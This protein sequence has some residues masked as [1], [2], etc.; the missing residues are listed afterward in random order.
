MNTVLLDM[1]CDE[2]VALITINRPQALNALSSEVLEDLNNALAQ[3]CANKDIYAL[4]ITGAGEKSFVAGADIAEMKDKNIDEAAAYGR[5]GNQIFTRVENFRCPVIAAVNGFALGGGCELAMAC[6]IR[7]ASSNAR[8]A[9]PEAGLGIT[10]G[11]GGTQRLARLIPVGV[12][13]EM[14]YTCRQVKVEEA[15][16]LGLVNKVVE[17]EALM[18]EAIK[19]AK[20]I[21]SNAPIA[22]ANCKTAINKGLQTDI[23]SAINIEV[24]QFSECFASEDQKTAMNAFVN[25]E[26]VEKFANK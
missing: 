6:D 14:I 4:I 2:N 24:K 19:M 15:L 16:S 20:R 17:Q 25:K 9:Q 8:F 5:L 11:F 13:K 3:V 26:K 22:V 18:A 7:I 10:P 12:A 1:H 23:D 21:A